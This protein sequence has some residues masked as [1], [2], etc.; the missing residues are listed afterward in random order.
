METVSVIIH[1]ANSANQIW[2]RYCRDEFTHFV[3]KEL[4]AR[5]LP[6]LYKGESP[7]F[8]IS[9]WP[10]FAPTNLDAQQLVDWFK[11]QDY[12]PGVVLAHSHGG[13]V[14]MKAS[15]FGLA[16]P[17]LILMGTP[18][19]KDYLPN[20][21]NLPHVINIYSHQDTTQELGCYL[22]LFHNE[23]RG[24]DTDSG[25]KLPEADNN[26]KITF[27]ASSLIVHSSLRTAKIWRSNNLA[28]YLG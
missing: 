16:V 11:K 25:R 21:A 14:V 18:I 23:A 8:W 7:F 27:P 12:S 15:W 17:R 9:K 28:Q 20:T 22:D 10:T 4:L 6:P 13:N 26:V 3:E 19:R 1:G 5:H 2:W 24:S